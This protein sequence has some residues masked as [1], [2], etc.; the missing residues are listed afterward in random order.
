MA[1][2]KFYRIGSSKESIIW[3]LKLPKYLY[4]I[5]MFFLLFLNILGPFHLA[6]FIGWFSPNAVTIKRIKNYLRKSWSVLAP[7]KV[8]ELDPWQK[9]L[10]Q[11]LAQILA[12]TLAQISGY[13]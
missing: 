12:Q 5:K 11:T 6:P 8:G 2:K 1:V 13:I 7:K 10:A 3:G 9:I 4:W